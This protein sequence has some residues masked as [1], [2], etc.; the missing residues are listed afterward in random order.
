MVTLKDQSGFESVNIWWVVGVKLVLVS[1]NTAYVT[2][3]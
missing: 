2:P 1:L 3:R